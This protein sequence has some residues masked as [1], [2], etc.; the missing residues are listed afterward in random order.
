MTKLVDAFEYNVKIEPVGR[1]HL[2]RLE[3]VPAGIERGDLVHSIPLTPRETV[4]ISHREWSTKTEEFDKLVTDL[5]DDYSEEGVTEKNELA[6]TVDTQSKH[7]T[8]LNV[9]TAMSASYSA[10]TLSASFGYQA[11]SDDQLAEKDSRDQSF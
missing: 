4:N 11:T 2:E 7:A 3:M 1:L 8:S 10:V 5:L 6:Q 9:G